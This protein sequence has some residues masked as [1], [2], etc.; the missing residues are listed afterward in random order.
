MISAPLARLERV[1]LRDAWQNESGDFTPWLGEEDNL[2]LLGDTIGLD[3]ELEAT[4]GNV[5]PFRADLL[6]KDTVT[7]HWVLVENQ[8]EQTDHTH[9]GQLLTYAAGLQAVT[10]VW[11]SPTFT[12]EHRATLDWL[13]N[14]TNDQFNFFGLEIELWRIGDSPYAPKFNIICKPNDWTKVISRAAENLAERALTATQQLQLEYWS[15]LREVLRGRKSNIRPRKPFPQ[16][17]YDFAIGRSGFTLSAW[18]NTKERNISTAIWINSPDAGAYY[19]LLHDQCEAIEN[20]IDE[21]LKWSQVEGRKARFLQLIRS[22]TDPLQRDGWPQ[23][24]Q[25]HADK[26]ELFYAVFAPRI[27]ALRPSEHIT[28]EQALAEDEPE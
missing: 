28:P 15:G 24:H 16:S 21:P 23:Q 25:W 20:E 12:E 9:L 13:N 11:L 10:V 18:M 2:K 5:G 4:E 6:C 3:L 17:Y 19:E 7:G 27:A 22:D 14:I 26:L 1:D 8:L